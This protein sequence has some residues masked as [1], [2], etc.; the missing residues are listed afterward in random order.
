MIFYNSILKADKGKSLV[1]QF[2]V[3]CD[4]H[5]IYQELMKH[6]LNPTATQLPGDTLLQYITTT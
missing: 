1:S 4:V 6:A 5:S 3:T 2:E